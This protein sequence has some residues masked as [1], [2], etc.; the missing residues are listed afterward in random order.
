MKPPPTPGAAAQTVR[1]GV[2]RAA[3]SLPPGASGHIAGLSLRVPQGAGPHEIAQALRTALSR[4]PR[5][6]G[7]GRA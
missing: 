1:T 6:D 2:E 5:R 4:R 7:E 3:D